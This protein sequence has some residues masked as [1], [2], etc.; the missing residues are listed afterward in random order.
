MYSLEGVRSLK[1]RFANV[2]APSF[3]PTVLPINEIEEK[4]RRKE[5]NGGG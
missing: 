1:D 5:K 4:E 3:L 2:Y